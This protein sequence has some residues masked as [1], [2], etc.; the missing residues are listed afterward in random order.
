M[1]L[2]R[3]IA[4]QSRDAL[5]LPPLDRI[6]R[7]D[8][9]GKVTCLL[10]HRV[11]EPQGDF[12]DRGGSP[13]IT[14]AELAG[15]LELLRAFGATFLTFQDLRRGRFPKPDQIAVIISFDDCFASNYTTGAEVL[16]RLG[17]RAT[18]FQT[19]ALVDSDDL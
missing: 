19:S 17:V 4:N 13:I 18:F 2:I 14:P 3:R 8:M 11:S 12:L 10:Y 5:F 15:D 7:G 1:Q 16:E 6:W 9:R